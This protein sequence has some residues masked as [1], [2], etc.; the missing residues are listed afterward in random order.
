LRGIFAREFFFFPGPPPPYFFLCG[1]YNFPPFFLRRSVD[2]FRIGLFTLGVFFQPCSFPSPRR[3]RPFHW[4]GAIPIFSS[5]L[6]TPFSLRRPLFF[7]IGHG[8]GPVQRKVILRNVVSPLQSCGLSSIFFRSVYPGCET[9]PWGRARTPPPFF[10]HQLKEPF[11]TNDPDFL[12]ASLLLHLPSQGFPEIG[13]W[14]VLL[15]FRR[16][17]RQPP[18]NGGLLGIFSVTLFPSVTGPV[19]CGQVTPSPLKGPCPTQQLF[20]TS[21]SSFFLLCLV[22]PLFLRFDLRVSTTAFF[23]PPKSGGFPP[24]RKKRDQFPS[25][26]VVDNYLPFSLRF[27][28][29]AIS[30][31]SVVVVRSMAGEEPV[32]SSFDRTF[33]QVRTQG[34]FPSRSPFSRNFPSKEPNPIPQSENVGSPENPGS[35][36][37]IPFFFMFISLVGVS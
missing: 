2:P 32:P 14:P 6:H 1:H 24:P 31:P 9:P 35:P 11:F 8:D 17:C 5:P 19:P 27:V 37:S 20:R 30:P 33:Y 4:S 22:P 28:G 29:Q 13:V 7:Y 16:W 10:G 21:D 26:L 15:F 3:L 12:S 34:Q 18:L 36:S 23:S 25:V